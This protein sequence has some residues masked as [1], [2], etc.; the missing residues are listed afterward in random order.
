MKGTQKILS[1]VLFV[2][3]KSQ[4]KA[5]AKEKV[6]QKKANKKNNNVTNG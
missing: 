5:N 4:K 3:K 1:G 6:T 2:K